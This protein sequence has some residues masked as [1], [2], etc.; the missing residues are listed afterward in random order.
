MPPAPLAE[1]LTRERFMREA[2]EE[3]ARG[4]GRT[5]P[6]PAVGAVLVKGGRIIARGHHRKAGGPHAEVVALAA[7]RGRARGADLYTTLEPCDHYGR[8]PPCTLAILEAGIRRVVAASADPN[9]L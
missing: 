2:L 7:A 4:L 9:P 8:T 5:S 3:A 1:R 6:N